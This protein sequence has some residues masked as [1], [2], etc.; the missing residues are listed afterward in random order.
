MRGTGF[1]V[2]I[3]RLLIV[4]GV[5]ALAGCAQRAPAPLSPSQARVSSGEDCIVLVEF[6]DMDTGRVFE[7]DVSHTETFEALLHLTNADASAPMRSARFRGPIGIYDLEPPCDASVAW[8]TDTLNAHNA[9]ARALIARF[10]KHTASRAEIS[11]TRPCDG[12]P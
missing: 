7:G 10:S 8:L 6:T 9:Q 3:V 5:I 12:G 2:F 11:C 1:F 4:S